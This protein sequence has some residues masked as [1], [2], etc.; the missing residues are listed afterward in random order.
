MFEML[1]DRNFRV[2]PK[3]VSGEKL[4]SLGLNG[5]N[6]YRVLTND[7]GQILLDPISPA[8]MFLGRLQ[9]YPDWERKSEQSS[10]LRF[11]EQRKQRYAQMTEEEMQK[12]EAA[13]ERFKERIDDNRPDGSK[14]YL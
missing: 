6:T 7:A 2:L 8:K 11:L 12:S 10:V 1:A 14:L 9:Q 13:F 4:N 3:L 5:A